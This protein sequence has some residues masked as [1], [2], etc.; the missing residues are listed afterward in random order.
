[1]NL[2]PGIAIGFA[3]TNHKGK[4]GFRRARPYIDRIYFGTSE[5]HREPQWIMPAYDFWKKEDRD[6]AMKDMSEVREVEDPI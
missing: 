5:W 2:K 1:M 3:Y 4:K 6:F